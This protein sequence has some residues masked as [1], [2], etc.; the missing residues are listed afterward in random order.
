[1]ITLTDKLKKEISENGMIL[2]FRVGSQMYGTNTQDSDEDFMGVC[3]P[4]K[5]FVIGLGKFEQFEERTN[6][7]SSGV[8]NTKDD[9]DFV[10]YSLIKYF[11][12]LAEGNPS[13]IETLF[14]P[15][16]CIQHKT[17]FGQRILTNKEI[18]LSLR[19]K[20]R[21]GGYAYSQKWK[22]LSQ[23]RIGSRKEIFDKY[24]FDCKFASHTIRLMLF[25]IELLKE[26]NLTLP[27]H[28]NNLLLDIKRGKYSLQE[29]MEMF[30]VYERQLELSYI[31]SNLPSKPDY[32]KINELQISLLEDFWNG[33]K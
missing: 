29:I 6:S 22:M 10:V 3:I 30:E 23:N 9:K 15:E 8:G 5:D 17:E 26:G 13:L 11:H 19:I 16:K 31:N 4:P 7:S 14:V 12:L 27:T 24:G 18:F 33:R 32:E 21:F 25:G 2:K 20:H 1:M 28:H